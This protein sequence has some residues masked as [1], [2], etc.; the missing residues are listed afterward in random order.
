M[1]VLEKK[2]KKDNKALHNNGGLFHW[3]MRL[4]LGSWE[5]W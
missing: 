2:N 1:P 4:Y 3:C 5:N